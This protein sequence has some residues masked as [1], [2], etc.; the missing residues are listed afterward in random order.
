LIWTQEGSESRDMW[1]WS[2]DHLLALEPDSSGNSRRED[3]C[4]GELSGHG[5]VDGSSVD[6]V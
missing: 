1:A 4:M 3:G 6:D 2:H 5:I